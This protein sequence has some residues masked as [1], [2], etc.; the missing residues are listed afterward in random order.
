MSENPSYTQVIIGDLK[1]L[2]AIMS[3]NRVVYVTAFQ[4]NIL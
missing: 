4:M 3:E 1:Q 2:S